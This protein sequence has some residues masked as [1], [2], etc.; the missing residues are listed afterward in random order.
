MKL[1]EAIIARVAAAFGLIYVDPCHLCQ[2]GTCDHC[3]L[4][5]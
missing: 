4:C 3:E 1:I 5:G 2:R